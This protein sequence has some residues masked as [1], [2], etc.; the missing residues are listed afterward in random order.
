MT[1]GRE[2]AHVSHLDDLEHHGAFLG[3]RLPQACDVWRVTCGRVTCALWR[4]TCGRVTFEL[5]R[6]KCNVFFPVTMFIA[7]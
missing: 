2:G 6:V 5:W 3:S 1:T 7:N 4:V